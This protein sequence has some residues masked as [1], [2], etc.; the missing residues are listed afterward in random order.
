MFVQVPSLYIRPTPKVGG[1]IGRVAQ[2]E[3]RSW[4]WRGR[5]VPCGTWREIVG[6]RREAREEGDM[7]NVFAQEGRGFPAFG[8]VNTSLAICSSGWFIQRYLQVMWMSC[9]SLEYVHLDKSRLTSPSAGT[10]AKKYINAKTHTHYSQ[11]SLGVF[12]QSDCVE[13]VGTVPISLPGV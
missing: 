9:S 5:R 4:A 7:R 12:H 6:W 13:S 8:A 11:W 2:E 3:P 1:S 10:Y